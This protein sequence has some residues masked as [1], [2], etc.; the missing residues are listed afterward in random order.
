MKTCL[1]IGAGQLGS[2][3]LQGLV[4]YKG[5][6]DV[7]VLDPSLKSL[8][9]A[10]ERE[11]EISHSH[12]VIYTQSWDVVPVSLDMV[13]IATSAN[14]RESVINQLL[15]KRKVC[16][17]ILEKVLFQELDAYKRVSDL[18]VKHNVVTFV[19]HPRRMFESYQKLKDNLKKGKQNVYQVAGGNWG[20]GCNALH[21]LDLFVYLSDERLQ[22]INLDYVDDEILS[23]SRPGFI[24]FTGTITGR[25]SD[26][27]FFSINS[28]EGEV[29]AISI[30][31]FNEEDRFIIQEGGTP[32][33]YELSKKDSFKLVEQDFNLEYISGITGK[34]A[35]DLFE[36]GNCSLPT[37]NDA[38]HTHELFIKAML[39][40]YNKITGLQSQILPIT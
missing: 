31:I 8:E 1:I 13:I 14:I 7:Y 29:S 37:F 27:S 5:E 16:F 15:L 38:R 25:L 2:R 6:M 33:I 32:R 30:T 35:I 9:I 4:K 40:K 3:H 11:R 23:S 34:L 26:G 12:K 17:L 39:E 28:L 19:N 21:F 18:L 36:K 22:E 24:E 20:I 10:T